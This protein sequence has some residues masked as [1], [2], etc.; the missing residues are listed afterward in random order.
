MLGHLAEIHSSRKDYPNV[1]IFS[2]SCL[3]STQQC[4]NFPNI[5]KPNLNIT[6]KTS[7]HFEKPQ[8]FKNKIMFSKPQLSIFNKQYKNFSRSSISCI[9]SQHF[10][11]LNISMQN[12]NNV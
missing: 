10:N 11:L 8:H 2:M 3:K 4:H 9:K 12:L 6:F 5:S 1:N 7:T